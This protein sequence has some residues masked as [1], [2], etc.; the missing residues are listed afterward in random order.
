MATTEA[1]PS[2]PLGFGR[3]TRKEDAR[4]V[5]GRGRYVDDI[6]LPGMLYGAILRSPVEEKRKIKTSTHQLSANSYSTF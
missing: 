2:V 1:P 3:M 6:V 5:R 4:F